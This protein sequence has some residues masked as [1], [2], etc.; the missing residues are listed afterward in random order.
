MRGVDLAATCLLL[1]APTAGCDFTQCPTPAE[2]HTADLPARLSETGLYSDV[3]TSALADGVAP[4]APRFELWSD[5]AEKHRWI[6]LPVGTRIDTSDMDNWIFPEGTKVWKEFRRDG[7]RVETR[8]FQ[9]VGP[10]E[11]D[12]VG[13]AYVWSADQRDAIATPEGATDAL[14]TAHDVPTAG[15]C[16]GCHAG[17]TSRVLGF[18][19]IQLST[20]APPGGLDLQGLIAAG[21]L[22]DPPSGDFS[23]PGDETEQTALGYL[24]ANCSHCHNQH[25]PASDGPRCYDPRKELDFGLYVDE[26]GAPERTG[27]YRTTEGVITPGDSEDSDVVDLVSKRSG[28]KHMPP[29][30]T[31]L[32]DED[33][34]ELLRN[35]IDRM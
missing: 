26:L 18:S 16:T 10:G 25:R 12:W 6:L 7:V 24:H 15:Q 4:Y 11:G 32:V 30:G 13:V 19:A 27:A 23:L 22:S 29:L 17:R 34:V 21:R 9:K 1:I 8:L 31:E 3:A 35:W 2:L 14:G 28:R 5:G 33:G 20:T